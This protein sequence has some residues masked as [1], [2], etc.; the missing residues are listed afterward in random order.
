METVELQSH[1]RY[2]MET[3]SGIHEDISNYLIECTAEIIGRTFDGSC[4]MRLG[5]LEFTLIRVSLACDEGADLFTLF[6]HNQEILSLA[7]AL[8]DP[9]FEKYA[10]PVQAVFPETFEHEDILYVRKIEVLPAA[11]GQRLGLSALYRVARDWDSGCGLVALNPHPLQ[12][13]QADVDEAE[14]HRLE[15]G[16]FPSDLKSAR[17]RLTRHFGGLGFRSTG[18]S[19]YLLRSSKLR[20]IPVDELDIRNSVSVPKTILNSSNEGS[21]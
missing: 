9:G 2:R 11:R 7:E 10:V 16:G 17:K 19:P 21:V 1:L 8:F 3:P 4:E 14:W 12:C 13:G 18:V 5:L 15:L 20:Q 6:D